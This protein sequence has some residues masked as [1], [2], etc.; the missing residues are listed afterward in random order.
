[1][2]VCP[3]VHAVPFFDYAATFRADEERL[4]EIFRRTGRRGAFILQDELR[5][6][7]ERLAA[8]AGVGH[9]VGVANATDGLHLA[10]R[11]A[12][13]GPGDEVIFSSHTM[14]ATAAA[15]HFAGATPV[16]VECGADHLIDPRAAAAALTPRTR[17]LLPTHLNG[18]LADLPALRA[19]AR[20]HGLLVIEDAAQALGARL[21][22]E[23][24]GAGTAA[25]AVSFYPAKSLGSLGDGGAVLTNDAELARRLRALRDHG[26]DESGAVACWGFNSRLDN[27]QAA[28][29]SARLEDY[30]AAIARRRAL[31]ARYDRA[32]RDL[33]EVALPPPPEE[34]GGRFD[35]FQNYEIEARDRDGLRRALAA[36]G[37][38]TLLPW[39]G[40]AVHQWPALGFATRLPYTE[41]MFERVL[42]LPLHPH[43]AG[44][45]VDA[46]ARAIREYYGR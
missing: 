38:G 45:D 13:I 24:A 39:G 23:G 42:L 26:R 33:A 17:A 16:P 40:R 41:R 36:R 12:G 21:D 43:L 32:L 1:M 31:A 28:F 11:A 22:G 34:G 10:L 35:I 9:A 2:T 5:E 8:F 46:V 37:I 15:I 14:V 20:W 18:R 3:P 30:G 4:V 25:A 27:L 6:F 7:E 29:L 44:D 19:L